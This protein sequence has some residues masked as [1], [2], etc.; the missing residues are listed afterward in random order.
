MKY[1]G[2]VLGEYRS[3]IWSLGIIWSYFVIYMYEIIKT[4]EKLCFKKKE[5]TRLNNEI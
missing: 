2:D 1:R 3:Q 4:K 5:I